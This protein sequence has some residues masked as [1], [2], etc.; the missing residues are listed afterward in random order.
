MQKIIKSKKLDPNVCLTWEN[1]DA[2]YAYKK[3]GVVEVQDR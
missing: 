1:N 3:L 2:E